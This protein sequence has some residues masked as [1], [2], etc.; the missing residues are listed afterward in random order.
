MVDREH[1]TEPNLKLTHDDILAFLVSSMQRIEAQ[2]ASEDPPA[3]AKKLFDRFG[4]LEINCKQRHG[5][6]K[7]S[8]LW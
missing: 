6:G 4:A 7:P 1:D 8:N 3:W 5:N 2:L